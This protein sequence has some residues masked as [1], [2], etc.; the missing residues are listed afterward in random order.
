MVSAL[1]DVDAERE[2]RMGEVSR[3]GMRST[4]PGRCGSTWP[5]H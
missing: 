4:P 2:R 5:D 1:F 3:D